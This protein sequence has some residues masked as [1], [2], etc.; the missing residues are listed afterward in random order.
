MRLT[1]RS[2]DIMDKFLNSFVKHFR[3]RGRPVLAEV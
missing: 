3:E 1:A 2:A